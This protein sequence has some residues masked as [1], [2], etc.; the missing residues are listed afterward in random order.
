M[1]LGFGL[2]PTPRVIGYKKVGYMEG[3]SR[4]PHDVRSLAANIFFVGV[5]LGPAH[6]AMAQDS[7]PCVS[8]ADCQAREEQRDDAARRDEYQ[9]IAA[10]QEA[11]HAAAIQV[12]HDA[13]AIAQG[14]REAKLE[15]ILA[16][17]RAAYAAAH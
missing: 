3:A 1:L 15:A 5:A 6:A 4:M 12:Q 13:R 9:R 8:R 10:G 16:R 2:P 14:N 17:R 7:T 11:A